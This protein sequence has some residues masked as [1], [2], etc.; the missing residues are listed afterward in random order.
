M[1]KALYIKIRNAAVSYCWLVYC[2]VYENI[3]KYLGG[4]VLC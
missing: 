4:M 1:M 2:N 3:F